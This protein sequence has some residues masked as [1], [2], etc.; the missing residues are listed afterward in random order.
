MYTTSH[1]SFSFLVLAH[2][3]DRFPGG[4]DRIGDKAE[5]DQRRRITITLFYYRSRC[6]VGDHS[7]LERCSPAPLTGG[8]QQWLELDLPLEARPLE[9][10]PIS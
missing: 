1:Q 2:S 8:L 4:P 3:S 7:H 5:I 6:C 10:L 9:A